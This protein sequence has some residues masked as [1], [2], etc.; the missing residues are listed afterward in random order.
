MEIRNQQH[1]LS[2]G[3]LPASFNSGH[4]SLPTSYSSPNYHRR[5][6]SSTPRLTHS[7][8][9]RN[10]RRSEP[11]SPGKVES[12]LETSLTNSEVRESFLNIHIIYFYHV[13][14]SIDT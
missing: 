7:L 11:V 3:S 1:R 13:F 2:V 4:L 12:E 9:V 10:T 14:I 5:P 8:S 6:R